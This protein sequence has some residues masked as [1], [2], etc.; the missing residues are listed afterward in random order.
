MDMQEPEEHRIWANKGEAVTCI[1]GHAICDIARN[2]YIGDPRSGDDFTNWR[3]PEP[4]KSTQVAE[5]RCAKCR[6]AWVRGNPQL[7]YQFHFGSE[8]HGGWR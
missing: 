1:N 7:G 5:I 8:K 3:Q 2:L 6:G 4:D